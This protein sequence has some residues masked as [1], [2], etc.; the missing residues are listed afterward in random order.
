MIW[1]EL[2]AIFYTL[3]YA[4]TV[5]LLKFSLNLSRIW[6]HTAKNI[7]GSSSINME[8]FVLRHRYFHFQAFEELPNWCKGDRE[9]I[10][11]NKKVRTDGSDAAIW[12]NLNFTERQAIQL[13]SYVFMILFVSLVILA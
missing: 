6:G 7:L 8:L 11:F 9:H 5:A 10:G 3:C 2:K 13:V 1:L 12:I 4:Q